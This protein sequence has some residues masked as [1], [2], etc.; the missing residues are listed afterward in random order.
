VRNERV[1]VF[2]WGSM[3]DYI[4]RWSVRQKRRKSKERR[5]ENITCSVSVCVWKLKITW[6]VVICWWMKQLTSISIFS[7]FSFTPKRRSER[8]EDFIFH[9]TTSACLELVSV[10]FFYFNIIPSFADAKIPSSL[11]LNFFL[12]KC[13]F[14]CFLY[15]HKK[16]VFFTR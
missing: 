10:F 14:I 6:I 8:E 1:W 3:R 15:A 2:V 12:S 7:M 16:Q 13:F 11:N 4:L 9:S 5:K